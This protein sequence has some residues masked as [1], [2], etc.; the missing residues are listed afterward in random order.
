MINAIAPWYGSNRMLG[1]HVGE[2]LKDCEWVGVPFAGGMSELKHI[3]ARTI[4]VS[5]LHRH[6]IN[7]AAVIS[8]PDMRE[9]LIERLDDVLFHP[10]CLEF[11]QARV[12]ER[13]SYAKPFAYPDLLAAAEYFVCSWM[14]RS[15]TAGTKT[16]LHAGIATR[17]NAGGGDS[18]VR[19]R[20]AVKSIEEW[21]AIA[22]RC[23]FECLDVFEFLK[24]VHDKKGHGL[25][26]DPP[27]PGPGDKYKHSFNDAQHVLLANRLATFAHTRVVCRFYD[28]LFIRDLYPEVLNKYDNS[29]DADDRGWKWHPL[30]GRDQANAEKPEVLLVLN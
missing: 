19:F 10:D 8:V 22:R 18:C 16:E 4:L 17:W 11:A 21:S 7:L 23:T 20:N 29:E 1:Q 14:A 27:F 13:E 3:K 12:A 26:L 2:L 25:Y 28:T 9:M 30:K 5:D 15:G 24:K 6:V